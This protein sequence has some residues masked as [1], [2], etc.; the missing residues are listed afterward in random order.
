VIYSVREATVADSAGIAAAHVAS[1]QTAYRGLLPDELLDNLSIEQRH[2]HWS[3]NL[4][5]PNP[6]TDTLVATTDHTIAGFATTGPRRDDQPADDDHDGAG[7]LYAIYLHPQHWGHGA[8]YHLHQEALQR[9]RHRGFA[10]A[11]LWVL[12]GNDR[13]I[14]FYQRAGWRANGRTRL[15]TRPDGTPLPELQLEHDLIPPS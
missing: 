5:T 12:T 1:W 6:R 15:D 2:A 8:G 10:T 7:E 14:T 4:T 9:L 11:T 13:A 3:R